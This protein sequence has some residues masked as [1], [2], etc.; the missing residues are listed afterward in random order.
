MT[1]V[2]VPQA[3]PTEDCDRVSPTLKVTK[4]AMLLSPVGLMEARAREIRACLVRRDQVAAALGDQDRRMREQLRQAMRGTPRGEVST[5]IVPLLQRLVVR[6]YVR[7]IEILTDG[8]DNS[9]V[10]LSAL[11][12]PKGVRVTFIIMRPNPLRRS[13]RLDDVLKAAD[14]WDRV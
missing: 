14:A 13:P 10:P 3:P 9:G 4:S 1:W 2:P 11:T 12:V 5:R 8:I 6:P 7:S